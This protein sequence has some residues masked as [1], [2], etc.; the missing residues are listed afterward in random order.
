M[1]TVSVFVLSVFVVAAAGAQSPQAAIKVRIT[2]AGN[3]PLQGDVTVTEGGRNVRVAN[4]HTNSE[5]WASFL[6]NTAREI[7][8]VVKADGYVSAERMLVPE[9]IGS[10]MTFV[11]SPAGK[12]SGRIIDESGRG[13]PDAVV[14]VRY[15]GRPRAHQLSQE[16]GEIVTDD[17]GYFTL[18]FV[19]RGKSFVIDVAAAGRPMAWSSP[20]TLPGESLSGIL[21]AVPRKSHPV[22]GRV[23]DSFGKP[24]PNVSIRLRVL[25]QP[26]TP[27]DEFE[28]ASSITAMLES[29]RIAVTDR[30]GMFEFSGVPPGEIVLIANRGNAKPISI[31]SK[32]A[33]GV[34][35]EVTIAVAEPSLPGVRKEA[36]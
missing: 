27:R 6:A 19:E 13:L 16:L 4:Y 22:R 34:P 11:L 7:A 14:R 32:V 33:A 21:I 9:A 2:T 5:G 30:D 36:Q 10:T 31:R 8:I 18:P 20:M 15:S 17:F 26:A 35:L 12:V 1:R 29:N 24:V 25:D 3:V 23:L 28:R